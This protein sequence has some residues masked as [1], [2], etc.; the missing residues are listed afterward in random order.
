MDQNRLPEDVPA[1]LH[2]VAD[3]NVRAVLVNQEVDHLLKMKTVSQH[4]KQSAQILKIN[5]PP[6][7]NTTKPPKQN[8]GLRDLKITVDP[9][10]VQPGYPVIIWTYWTPDQRRLAV[11]LGHDTILGM[12]KVQKETCQMTSSRPVLGCVRSTTGLG[13]IHT[14]LMGIYIGTPTYLLSPVEFA[15]NPMSLFMILSR[16]KIKDTYATP[17]MLDHA[18]ALIPGKGFALHELKNMMISA[19]SRPRIDVFQKVRL[20]FA[21]TGLDRTAINTVYSHV[22][23]PMV[24]SRSYMCIEPIELWL[25]T[26][27]L[28]RGL[29]IPTDPDTDTKALLLQDSGMVPVSTQMANTARSGSTPRPASNVSMVQRTSSMRRGSTVGQLMETQVSAT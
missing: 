2:L 14:C 22:L 17:Q 16:Y 10:W 6:C 29:V 13:F 4:I 1:F 7:Y 23:N 24:A 12:C 15:Q 11:Q 28:R 3:Y 8:N 18:M 9:S 19:E 27:A 26:K 20:H 21:A 25:D 5:V